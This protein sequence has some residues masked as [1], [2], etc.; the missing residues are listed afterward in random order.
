MYG[1]K[2]IYT[3]EATQPDGFNF[4]D[5]KNRSARV[6]KKLIKRF[7]SW[8]RRKPCIIRL[9]DDTLF[10]HPTLRPAIEAQYRAAVQSAANN[11]L[12]GRP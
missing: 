9:G 4:P 1:L 6:W 5:S 11:V 8:E 3:H 10:V 7:G 12:G 2:I